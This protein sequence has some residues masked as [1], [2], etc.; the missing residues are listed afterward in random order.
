MNAVLIGLFMTLYGIRLW[1]DKL[2]ILQLFVSVNSSS[3]IYIIFIL[4]YHLYAILNMGK[5]KL[6]CVIVHRNCS[7]AQAVLNSVCTKRALNQH[8]NLSGIKIH[9]I[10]FKLNIKK[11]YYG[12][13]NWNIVQTDVRLVHYFGFRNGHPIVTVSLPCQPFSLGGNHKAFTDVK[14]MFPEAVRAVRE[15]KP[16]GF[17]FEIVKGLLRKSFSS[18][19][20][21]ILLQPSHPEMIVTEIMD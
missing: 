17:I 11:G 18:Y 12:I 5:K 1:R 16:Q 15:F 19:L 4:F 3:K 8:R 9:S 10:K 6:Y 21:Y 2:I 20:N 7:V 14:D 13:S